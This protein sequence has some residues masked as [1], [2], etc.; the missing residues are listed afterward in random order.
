MQQLNAYAPQHSR[1]FK[2]VNI[3]QT[4]N[5]EI[6]WSMLTSCVLDDT[7]RKADEAVFIHR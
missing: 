5:N 2:E 3:P 6:I 7:R 1:I 4:S